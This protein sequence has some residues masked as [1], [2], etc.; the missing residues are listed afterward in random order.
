M[1]QCGFGGPLK[2]TETMPGPILGWHPRLV[3]MDDLEAAKTAVLQALA[4]D[5]RF[6]LSSLSAKLQTISAAS[7]KRERFLNTLLRAG[8]P[9]G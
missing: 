1:L 4:L 9:E 3:L 5:P 7:D 8:M 2:T 6:S